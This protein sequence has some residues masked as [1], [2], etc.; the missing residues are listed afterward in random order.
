[1]EKQTSK[2]NHAHCNFY[3]NLHSEEKMISSTVTYAKHMDTTDR[4][5][6]SVQPLNMGA[7]GG[8]GKVNQPLLLSLKA[9]FLLLCQQE[10]F[11]LSMWTVTAEE[12]LVI[13]DGHSS[14]RRC[15]QPRITGSKIEA[16][17]T[18]SHQWEKMG[19]PPHLQ[20]ANYFTT[21]EVRNFMGREKSCIK[22]KSDWEIGKNPKPHWKR[23]PRRAV[24]FLSLEVSKTQVDTV[25]S[26][27]PSCWD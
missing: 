3:I 13:S 25:L 5:G 23:F 4:L 11:Q 6:V 15:L 9:G 22:E 12:G 24:D 1:M 2:Q 18:R 27:L 7:A 17:C 16:A 26:D 21:N 20:L 8:A 19:T 14:W 10:L